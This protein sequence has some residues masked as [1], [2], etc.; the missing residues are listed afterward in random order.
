MNDELKQRLLKM[1]EED[2]RVRAELA[3]TG[4]LLQGYAP[5]MAEVHRRNAQE[6]Q[7]IIERF[8]WPGKTLV[9]EWVQVGRCFLHCITVDR[10]PLNYRVALMPRQARLDIPGALHHI[11]VR[12]INKSA[13]FRD[14]QERTCFLDRLGHNIVAAACS[15]YAWVLM[16]N[17]YLCGAQHNTGI[18]FYGRRKMGSSLR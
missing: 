14:D 16:D 12:G 18:S 6:L 9:G 7:I 13:I 10:T 15:A 3:A 11:I 4:E 5:R 2:Q 1:A 8:G 17:H